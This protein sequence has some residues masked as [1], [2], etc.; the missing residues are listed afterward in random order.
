MFYFHVLMSKLVLMLQVIENHSINIVTKAFK[1]CLDSYF[2][3]DFS[4]IY[5]HNSILHD[6]LFLVKLFLSVFRENISKIFEN[7]FK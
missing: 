4:N 3:G 5:L 1:R 7:I 2:S 6:I